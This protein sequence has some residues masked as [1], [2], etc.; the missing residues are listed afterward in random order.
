[1]NSQHEND[2]FQGDDATVTVFLDHDLETLRSL[3]VRDVFEITYIFLGEGQLTIGKDA[4]IFRQGDVFLTGP[5][6]Q[7]QLLFKKGSSVLRPKVMLHR[8]RFRM[9]TGWRDSIDLP[10][11]SWMDHLLQLAED[12]LFIKGDHYN[13][14]EKLF[15]QMLTRSE[16]ISMNL[17][18]RYLREIFELQNRTGKIMRLTKEQ[19]PDN[20][21]K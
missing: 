16:K 8:T 10:G 12:G 2:L 18:L 14:L 17:F 20:T 21:E 4:H 19:S 6:F 5:R 9:S 13:E 15:R 11:N 7:H 1:M 3:Q